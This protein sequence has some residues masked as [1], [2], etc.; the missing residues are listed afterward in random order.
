MLSNHRPVSTPLAM[1]ILP[2]DVTFIDRI[3]SNY[4]EEVFVSLL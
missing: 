3:R 4:F 2:D 1:P